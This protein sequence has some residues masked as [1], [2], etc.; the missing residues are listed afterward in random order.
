MLKLKA[1]WAFLG[2]VAAASFACPLLGDEPAQDSIPGIGPVGPVRQLHGDFKFVEGPAWDGHGNLYFTDIPDERIYKLDADGRLSVFLEYSGHA[3]GLMFAADGNLIACQMDGRLAKIDV[4][5][6]QV[7]PLADT[8]EGNRF[9]A[10][11]DLVID[12]SG[13]VYFTDPHFGAPESRPQ[14]KLAVY[15]RSA[16]GNVTRLIDDLPAPNGVI[17]AP[18]EK[19][20]YIIPSLQKEMLAYPVCVP[21]KPGAGRVFCT[22]AQPEGL[23]GKGGD[24]LTI[25]TLGNLYITSPLGVQVFDPAGKPLGIIKFPEQP[26]NVTFGGQHNQTLFATARTSLYA[27]EMEA[28]G[29]QFARG[30]E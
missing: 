23:T 3:N 5:S 1:V 28:T 24:G 25:D 30:P 14:D 2:V 21:G 22:L 10:P 13:G 20:L 17:L 11:N 7:M 16:T 15:Y 4:K 6:K 19:T 12:R 9:N 26:A 18:D 8:Y 27:V 29:H